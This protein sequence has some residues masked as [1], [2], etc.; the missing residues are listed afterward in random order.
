MTENS[1]IINFGWFANKTFASCIFI[2]IISTSAGVVL[3]FLVPLYLHNILEI[4]YI[5]VGLYLFALTFPTVLFSPL[6]GYLTDKWGHRLPII[7]GSLFFIISTF[8][9]TQ[10]SRATAHWFL[11]VTFLIFGMSWGLIMGPVK[12]G[13]LN[14]LPHRKSGVGIGALLSFEHLGATIF[15]AIMGTVFRHSEVLFLDDGLRSAGIDMTKSRAA[16][17]QNLLAHPLKVQ[18]NIQNMSVELQEKIIPLFKASFLHGFHTTFLS[19]LAFA[20]LAFLMF[21]FIKQKQH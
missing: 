5:R 19:V 20:F 17:I 10:F 6:A 15:L 9:I 11:V 18:Q 7:I 12:V 4:S 21:L 1:P 14:S 16:M 2:A 13:V 8:M 3:L